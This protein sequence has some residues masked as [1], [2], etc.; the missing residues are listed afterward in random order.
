MNKIL[1]CFLLIFGVQNSFSQEIELLCKGKSSGTDV[2]L[3]NHE[4]PMTVSFTIPYFSGIPIVLVPACNE[5][6]KN[7]PAV[8]PACTVTSNELTCN[9]T[10]SS[11]KIMSGITIFNLSRITGRLRINTYFNNKVS[12]EGEYFCEKITARKF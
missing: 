12:W 3:E 8:I 6:D 5:F 2:R 9:C 1:I 11:G 7:K 4:F 10:N